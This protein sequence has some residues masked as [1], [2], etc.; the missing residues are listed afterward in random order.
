MHSQHLG[1]LQLLPAVDISEGR[2]V[3]PVGGQLLG[4]SQSIDPVAAAI[5]WGEAGAE[6]IHLVDLDLAFGR[7]TNT[8]V[9]EQVID[10]VRD[11][12]SNRIKIQV[13]GGIKDHRSIELALS[14]RPDRINVTSAALAQPSWLEQVL[15]EHGELLALGVDV[16][17]GVVVARGT[18]WR[19]DT[20]DASIMW[21]ER[22]GAQ[23]YVVTDV[24]RDGAL[25]GPGLEPLQHVLALTGK[26]VIASG[27]VASLND[28][29][30]LRGM[31]A[32]GLEAL[33]LGKALYTGRFT[34]EQALQAANGTAE[35]V[36]VQEQLAWKPPTEQAESS[37]E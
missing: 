33:V 9:L 29:R 2:A 32:Q 31:T 17:D 11:R 3:R 18:D 19:G 6:W 36:S 30:V 5:T 25:S 27:G 12:T 37:G 20:L 22:A 28:I 8:S 34:L 13:S 15:E 23:R 35:G 26:P 14:L 10:E 16:R 24:S 21:L 4:T 7:G 1:K